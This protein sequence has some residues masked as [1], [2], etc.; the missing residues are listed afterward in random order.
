MYPFRSLIL[1]V[2]SKT[3][4][5]PITSNRIKKLSEKQKTLEVSVDSYLLMNLIRSL[6]CVLIRGCSIILIITI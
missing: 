6:S 3:K 2:S 4:T 1:H 5:N